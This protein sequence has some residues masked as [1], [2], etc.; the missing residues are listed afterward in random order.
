MSPI[1]EH[2]AS[3]T[4]SEIGCIEHFVLCLDKETNKMSIKE[5]VLLILFGAGLGFLSS[6]GT[7]L[8]S[9]LLMKK[10]GVKIYYKIVFSKSHQGRTW[11]FHNSANGMIFEVPMW[12]ELYNTSNSVQVIRDL[13][14]LLFQNGKEL[15]AMTQ[16]NRVGEDMWYGNQGAY[17]FVLQPRNIS[18]YDLHFII[19]QNELGSNCNF[20]EIRLR[21]FDEKNKAHILCLKQISQSWINGDLERN[22]EWA[23]AQ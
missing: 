22:T 5:Q 13:V 6:I 8:V 20:D 15:T 17:S 12:V 16:I 3:E 23:L 1:Q 11:G 10:G 2:W 21:Y 14:I 9:D 18:K 7:T 4:L 19:K